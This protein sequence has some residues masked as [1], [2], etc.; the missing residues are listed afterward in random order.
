[1][2]QKGFAPILV[3]VV[4]LAIFLGGYYLG[5][6]KIKPAPSQPTTQPP[7]GSYQQDQQKNS[8][9]SIFQ[10]KIKE[11]C[12]TKTADGIDGEISLSS[13]DIRID[14]RILPST[15]AFCIRW[16]NTGY[17]GIEGGKNTVYVYD[18]YSQ[19][20]PAGGGS[21]FGEHD[22]FLIKTSGKDDDTRFFLYF[23]DD[24][25]P[26]PGR[27]VERTS[28]V[29]RGD[30]VLR[31]FY[32]EERDRDDEPFNFQEISLSSDLTVL[33][34]GNEKLVS[35]MKPFIEEDTQELK[36]SYPELIHE[37]LNRFPSEVAAAISENQRV[38]DAISKR[39]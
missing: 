36:I 20:L 18:S 30:K 2:R 3:I 12:K 33:E 17:V 11:N 4:I 27:R 23:S 26:E 8:E 7:P 29:L 37:F 16:N 19:V 38:L 1:M 9:V 31:Y 35:F 21:P 39:F 28:F 6:Q 25:S 14:E 34:I 5:Q 13:L 32:I 22:V 10:K 24:P 15:R